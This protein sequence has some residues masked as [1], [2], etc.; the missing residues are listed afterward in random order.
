MDVF[1][2]HFGSD[3]TI[4]S[5]GGVYVASFTQILTI[6]KKIKTLIETNQLGEELTTSI[7]R[8]H[9]IEISINKNETILFSDQV[10]ILQKE[11]EK[12]LQKIKF[13]SKFVD[14]HREAFGTR[15]LQRYVTSKYD[16][17]N[18]DD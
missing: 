8:I 2:K 15:E 17:Y 16:E 3:I 14:N 11:L 6:C 10:G 13:A 4:K 5:L 9:L 12:Y 7:E 18:N 1:L